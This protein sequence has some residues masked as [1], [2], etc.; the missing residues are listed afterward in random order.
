MKKVERAPVKDIATTTHP[1][2]APKKANVRAE[3][4]PMR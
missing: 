1:N 4:E 2:S 3:P